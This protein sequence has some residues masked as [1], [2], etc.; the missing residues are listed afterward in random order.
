MEYISTSGNPQSDYLRSEPWTRSFF[1][2]FKEI[3]SEVGPAQLCYT[4]RDRRSFKGE[5]CTQYAFVHPRLFLMPRNRNN[6]LPQCVEH[7]HC[8]TALFSEETTV[9]SVGFPPNTNL[10]YRTPKKKRCLDFRFIGAVKDMSDHIATSDSLPPPLH[11]YAVDSGKCSQS[12]FWVPHRQVNISTDCYCRI[13]TENLVVFF[14]LFFS[15]VPDRCVRLYQEAD[16]KLGWSDK[17]SILIRI[18]R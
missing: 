5:A 14:P 7:R 6:H 18:V 3:D 1:S 10:S 16:S 8:S 12:L 4:Q 9:S 2:C 11:Y 15:S 13:Q 17:S